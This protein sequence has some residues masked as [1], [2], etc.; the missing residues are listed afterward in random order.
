MKKIIKNKI[1][2]FPKEVILWGGTGQAKV[3]R[4][5]IEHYGSKVVAVFDHTPKLK[6]PFK[7]VPLFHESE[8][9]EWLSKQTNKQNIGFCVTI[10]NPRGNIRLKIHEM[11]KNS[12]LMPVTLSHPSAI[13]AK[14]AQ[15]GEGT[16]IL[17]GAII[18]PE[19]VLGKSCIINT[20]A[21][22]D[23]ECILEDG[24]EIAP[25]ATLCGSI[26]V[27]KYSWVAS[28]ATVLPWLTIG[29][30]SIV[31]AGAIVV[32]DVPANQVVVGIPAR[33]LRDIEPIK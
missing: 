30:N 22:V 3:V 7:E 26:K 6:P 25:G 4:P 5:I 13:I 10:G 31:G 17:A 27:G 24:V 32:N 29:E 16:Q 20:K 12:G 33:K 8:F 18:Q 28:G 21:S 23:H 1:N 2:K 11:L 9:P 15:I 19:A 14:N